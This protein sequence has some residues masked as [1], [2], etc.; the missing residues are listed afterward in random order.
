MMPFGTGD[1][2]GRR[3]IAALNRPPHAA[4]G[5]TIRLK[6]FVFSA[7]NGRPVV[8]PKCAPE[9]G[10]SA[11]VK[12]TLSRERGPPGCGAVAPR[13]KMAFLRRFHAKSKRKPSRTFRLPHTGSN[14]LDEARSNERRC[15]SLDS[16]DGGGGGLSA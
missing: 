4:A 5:V 9:S 10:N 12:K 14:R 11:T 15:V 2:S 16:G 7:K 13:E 8:L 1:R 6:A 3:L